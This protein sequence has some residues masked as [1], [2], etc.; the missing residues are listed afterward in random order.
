MTVVENS[1]AYELGG[2]VAELYDAQETHTRDL[3]L[4]RHLLQGTGALRVLEPFCGTGRILI[5]LA[6][7]GH[8]VLGL[9]RAEAMLAR[10]RVKVAALVP[11][12]QMRVV[13]TCADVLRFPWQTGFD[14]VV[15]G[16]NCLYELATAED[17]ASVIDRAGASLSRGGHLY[18]DN[19]HMEGPL[20][21]AWR[22]KVSE[23]AF[24]TGTCADG[25]RLESTRRVV[26]FDVD[27]RL[28]QFERTVSMIAPDGTRASRTFTEQ[29]HPPSFAEMQAWVESSGLS[30]EACFGDRD[31][32]PYRPDSPRAIFWAVKGDRRTTERGP[33]V[34]PAW[35]L[36][37]NHRGG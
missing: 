26:W 28:A 33:G 9:D 23:P 27:A 8:T 6:T 13:L 30:V 34:D 1:H 16:G 5:P 18:L 31:G 35:V 22:S 3:A 4:L 20:D 24:P 37:E 29:K 17:Q 15:L 12:V 36:R 19:D 14:L 11:S 21:L 2:Y 7:D 32:S 25:T 10:A